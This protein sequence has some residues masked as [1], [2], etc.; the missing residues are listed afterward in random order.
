MH[1]CEVHILDTLAV[2]MNFVFLGK[3]SDPFGDSPFG[4]VAFV[5]KRRN[6]GD[7][8]GWHSFAALPTGLL[9]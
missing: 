9:A 3:A 8:D 6:N 1:T 2:N 7:P 4:S 5:D